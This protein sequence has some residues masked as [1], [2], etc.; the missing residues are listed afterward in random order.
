VR[1]FISSKKLNAEEVLQ[2]TRQHWHVEN[3][4]HW[5]LD[6]AFSEDAEG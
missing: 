5:V 1:Y 2:A 4:L 6:V 3:R